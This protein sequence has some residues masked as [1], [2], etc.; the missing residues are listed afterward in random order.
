MFKTLRLAYKNDGTRNETTKKFAS[1]EEAKKY[2]DRW[3]R[4][5]R[6]AVSTSVEVYEAD[7]DKY[8]KCVYS[9]KSEN[10]F[11]AKDNEIVEDNKSEIAESQKVKTNELNTVTYEATVFTFVDG[12]EESEMDNEQRSFVDYE[13]A[14]AWCNERE[15][16]L[17]CCFAGASIERWDSDKYEQVWDNIDLDKYET[18]HIAYREVDTD[19]TTYEVTTKDFVG[20]VED[21]IAYAKRTAKEIGDNVY[22]E[23]TYNDKLYS[24]LLQKEFKTVY[25]A[26]IDD[27][28][29]YYIRTKNFN[30]YEEAIQFIENN[31]FVYSL[32]GYI[33]KGYD[34][35]GYIAKPE[36]VKQIMPR[37]LEQWQNS[38]TSFYQF[39][40]V[41]DIV[42]SP[43]I[44]YFT[45]ILP[46]AKYSEGLLQVGEPYSHEDNPKTGGFEPTFMTFERVGKNWFFRGNC[47]LGETENIE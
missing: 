2:A 19:L 43:I 9:R 33:I 31:M 23:I 41:G 38:H 24:T 5:I 21:T 47:F 42:D 44:E 12:D 46:P 39:I 37:T 4:N 8:G 25:S 6:G 14:K 36:R 17:G 45:D 11:V 20:S 3:A 15:R 29:G 13:E 30:S 40:N 26:S 22:A 18:K 16:C 1:L 10:E 27:E 28:P 34:M 32:A 7:G 35:N